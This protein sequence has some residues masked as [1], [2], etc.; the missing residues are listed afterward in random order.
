MRQTYFALKLK[1]IKGRGYQT[2]NSK[3]EKK[4]HKK[5]AKADEEETMQE[6]AQAPLV[7]HENNILHSIFFIVEV[8]I[9]LQQIYNSNGPYA[10]NSYL[11]NNFKGA[12]SECE[13]ILY[14]EGYN[15]GE[16]PDE[17]MEAPLPFSQ[18]D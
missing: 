1:L 8:Y 18:R 14:C 6:Q 2:Y 3:E 7:T 16:F 11:S 12:I 10:H 5:E 9:N 4:V 17:I 15:Y 13:G